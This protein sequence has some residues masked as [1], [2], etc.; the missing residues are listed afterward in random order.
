M[1]A[2]EKSRFGRECDHDPVALVGNTGAAL[3][4][5]HVRVLYGRGL[6][7]HQSVLPVIHGAGVGVRKSKVSAARDA[8]VHRECCT[9]VVAGSRTLE[10][11]D[12]SKFRNR[13]PQRIDAR[14]PPTLESTGKLPR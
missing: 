4:A 7:S 14:G 1:T 9:V 8:S 6:T 10:F 13:A 11:I 5:R 2:V 12:R 3:R